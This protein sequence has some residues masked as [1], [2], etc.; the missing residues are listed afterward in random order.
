MV[1]IL[2]IIDLFLQKNHI[3]FSLCFRSVF[4]LFILF[5]FCSHYISVPTVFQEKCR[6]VYSEMHTNLFVHIVYYTKLFLYICHID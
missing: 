6:V 4:K 5:I 2:F 3:L 1:Y